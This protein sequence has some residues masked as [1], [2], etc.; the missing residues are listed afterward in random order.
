V[1]TSHSQ[2]RQGITAVV[3]DCHRERSEDEELLESESI[4][5]RHRVCKKKESAIKFSRIREAH[6]DGVRN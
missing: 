5:Y 6:V 3:L 2:D 4:W 1:D